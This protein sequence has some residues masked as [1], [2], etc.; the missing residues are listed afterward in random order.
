MP[1]AHRE[2]GAA[3]AAKDNATRAQDYPD[4]HASH[5]AQLLSLSVE[6]YGRW[7]PDSLRLVQELASFRSRHVPDVIVDSIRQSCARR[8]WGVLSCAV[9]KSVSRSV[10]QIDEILDFHR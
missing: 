4:V 9:Q 5:H 3:L 10:L 6:T 7:G 2:D 8:W 1:R